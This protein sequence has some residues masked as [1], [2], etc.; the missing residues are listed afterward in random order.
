MRL[1]SLHPSYLDKQ[2]LG[3]CWREALLAQKVLAGETKGYKNHS[4]LIRFKS[5]S[6]PLSYISSFLLSIHEESKKRGYKYDSSKILPI[7]S[8]ETKI[9]VTRGQLLYEFNHLLYNKLQRRSYDRFCEYKSIIKPKV[10][11]FFKLVPGPIE[12][13]E[14]QL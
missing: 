14:K 12:N 9:P 10:N 2:G 7:K 4:Q 13:W 8:I 1:W 6:D 5:T 11:P 3:G